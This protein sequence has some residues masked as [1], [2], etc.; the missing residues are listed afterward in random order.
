MLESSGKNWLVKTFGI[1]R[2]NAF[3]PFL[4]SCNKSN[5]YFS[6]ADSKAVPALHGVGLSL[7]FANMVYISLPKTG[8]TIHPSHQFGSNLS[9][10][11]GSCRLLFVAITNFVINDNFGY[12]RAAAV[13]F[14]QSA[15]C[16]WL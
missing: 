8:Q 1:A 13:V 6:Y 10:F 14:N 16:W 4:Y 11:M 9:A 2:H 15:S 3:P 12:Q 5:V 7:T